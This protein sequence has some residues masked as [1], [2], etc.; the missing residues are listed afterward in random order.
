MSFFRMYKNGNKASN[1]NKSFG[2]SQ[3]VAM[4]EQGVFDTIRIIIIIISK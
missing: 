1:S 2:L 4:C 3:I